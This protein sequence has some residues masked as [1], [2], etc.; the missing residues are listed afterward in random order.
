MAAVVT[1][2]DVRCYLCHGAVRQE[3]KFEISPS[4]KALWLG[5]ET[6]VSTAA[7]TFTGKAATLKHRRVVIHA[8]WRSAEG[9]ARI[10]L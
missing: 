6:V 8:M 3:D 9:C 1:E 4:S 2:G 5:G 10:S 7:H